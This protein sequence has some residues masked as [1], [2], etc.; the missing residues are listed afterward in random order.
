MN[1][2]FVMNTIIGSATPFGEGGP[3]KGMYSRAFQNLLG[4]HH[5]IQSVHCVNNTFSDSGLFGITLEGP[6]E[7]S[8]DLL[9]AICKELCKLRDR[10]I[11]D[12]ELNR[13]KNIVKMNI[14]MGLENQDHRLEEIARNYMSFGQLTF[15]RYCSMIDQVTSS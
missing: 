9:L 11:S 5:F 1:A 12:E 7:H 8:C 2:L 10:A 4:Q 13:A 14:L 15:H 3:G 6:N